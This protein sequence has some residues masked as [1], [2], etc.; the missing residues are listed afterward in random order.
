MKFQI[1][2]LFLCRAKTIKN[3]VCVNVE[4][5]AEQWKK[6]YEKEKEKNKTLRNTIQWLE[7]ELNRWRNG[8]KHFDFSSASFK[9]DNRHWISLLG[10]K[11]KRT[12]QD[13]NKN[14]KA[15]ILSWHWNFIFFTTLQ[16]EQPQII[17]GT[18]V[19]KY[20]C[21]RLINA[22]FS[23]RARDTYILKT[24]LGEKEWY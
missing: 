20:I 6:K 15:R 10:T 2:L 11:G 1:F 18:N 4:L 9:Q 19:C 14:I 23:S 5:T 12:M 16:L 8:K 22:W 3:T 7:N 21:V 24:I 17:N 13:S